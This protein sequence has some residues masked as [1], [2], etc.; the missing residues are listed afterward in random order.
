LN[1]GQSSPQPGLHTMGINVPYADS[2]SARADM[3][4]PDGVSKVWEGFC[5]SSKHCAL[6][7]V[8]V[9]ERYGDIGL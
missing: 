8:R 3:R 9:L 2:G 7:N 6:G 1:P 5:A 4:S